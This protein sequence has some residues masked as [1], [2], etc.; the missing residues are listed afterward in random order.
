MCV[1]VCVCF[2]FLFFFFLATK[3]AEAEWVS[4]KLVI[5][6]GELYLCMCMDV[7]V[8]CGYV[9]MCVH[10][11]RGVHFMCMCVLTVEAL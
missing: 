9:S 3:L 6:K 5:L 4:E 11:V 8:L 2:F 10:C 1:S 7:C